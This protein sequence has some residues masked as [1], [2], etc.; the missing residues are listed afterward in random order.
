[1]TVIET[2]KEKANEYLA[3]EALLR[4]AIDEKSKRGEL[5]MRYADLPEWKPYQYA[6]DEWLKAAHDAARL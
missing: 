1:M 4:K 3:F 2:I 5:I 6:R